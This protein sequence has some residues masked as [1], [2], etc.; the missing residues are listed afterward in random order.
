MTTSGN[1]SG[2]IN[3]II[4]ACRLIMRMNQAR[5]DARK[6]EILYYQMLVRYYT[7][8]LNARE[9]GDFI[10]AHT[11]F[12]PAEIIYAMG[13]VPMH[14]EAATWTISLFTGDCSDML[15]KGSE[16]G[17]A[18][19]I[20]TPH[21]GLA[22]AYAL[23]DLPSP[24]AIVWS[25]MV[26]D[27]TAKSGELIMEVCNCPGFFIDRPFKDSEYEKNYLVGELQVGAGGGRRQGRW[28][29]V[30]SAQLTGRTG[31]RRRRGRTRAACAGR[32]RRASA[33]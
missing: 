2:R 1:N 14:T 4:R 32:R 23:G 16:L 6:S 11:V 31:A 9:N 27:N 19:E 12:F 26:C 24:D 29:P 25:N 7:R 17:L 8:L 10:V 30:R 28:H 15:S 18:S 20:C 13:L 3:A 22:G 5:P 33:R 21:R